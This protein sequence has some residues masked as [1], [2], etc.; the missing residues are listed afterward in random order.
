MNRSIKTILLL[1][2]VGVVV[3]CYAAGDLKGNPAVIPVPRATEGKAWLADRYTQLKTELGTRDLSKV[4]LLFVGDSITQGWLK[5]GAESWTASFSG[6]PNHA[7]NLGVAG[8][9]T[10]HVL[11]RLLSAADGGMG[12][13]D[14]PR[15]K[16][17]II[18]LMIGTNNLFNN[19]PDE[20]IE[21]VVAVCDRLRELE[22]QARIILCSIL[23]TKDDERNRTLV[24]PVNRQLQTLAK[25][26]WLD[27]YPTFVNES[28]LQ[29]SDFFRDGLHPNA[30]GYRVWR[31][32]LMHSIIRG[33]S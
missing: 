17:K 21:G 22:P 16:P 31:D 8:D 15:L 12:N 4:E 9:R 3:G 5:E 10:E 30:D 28:G 18:V 14:D 11:Y 20:I 2:V 33:N 24:V 27:L 19:P 26:Q 13:L 25:V 1:G 32:L 29:R 23:P 6:A 7:L